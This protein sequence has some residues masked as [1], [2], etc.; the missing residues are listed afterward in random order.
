MPKLSDADVKR[1]L[2]DPSPAARA[3]VAGK[4][5][6]DFDADLSPAERQLAEEIVRKLAQDMADTVRLSLS[7]NLKASQKLPRDVALKLARDVESVALPVLEHST[8]LTDTDLLSFI[9][10]ATPAK[11]QAM[12][13]RTL[14]SEPVSAALVESGDEATV[15]TLV[16]NEGAKL[17]DQSM[18]RVVDRFGDRPVVQQ[19]L[20]LRKKLPV[21]VAERLVA[22]VSDKLRDHLVT[23]HELSPAVAADLVL[24]NRERATM[25]L[26]STSVKMD[27]LERLVKQLHANGRLTPS[28]MLRSLCMGDVAFFEVAMA[29][30]AELPLQ[31]ARVLLHDRGEQALAALYQKAG[32]PPSLFGV[33]K[34]A[35]L[36]IHETVIE[37]EP[38]ARERYRR[39]II[40]RVLSQAE[41]LGPEDSD[42]LLA[43]LG[44]VFAGDERMA[45][46]A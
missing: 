16:A 14:V 21:T 31:N 27:E 24:Q 17:S 2:S 36:V 7:Q 42:Y 45:A 44:D 10:E 41:A 5:A 22:V 25:N 33:I 40:E 1:L 29:L 43:K 11:H 30:R 8:V 18:T 23:H 13:R 38:F 12:A 3:E 32:L 37:D 28:I 15:A 20:V 26:L 35:L 46:T 9:K 4:L 34:A 6:A 39:R 19:P